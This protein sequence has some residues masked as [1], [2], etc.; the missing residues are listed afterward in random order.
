MMV[1]LH[2]SDNIL[3]SNDILDRIFV[4]LFIVM[5]KTKFFISL[6]KAR[7]LLTWTVL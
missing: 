7:F 4:G 3:P 1:I 2:C 6:I 5:F